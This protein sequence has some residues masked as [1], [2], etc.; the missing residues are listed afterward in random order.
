MDADIMADPTNPNLPSLDVQ[1]RVARLAMMAIATI[2]LPADFPKGARMVGF[3]LMP[4]EHSYDN[5]GIHMM[6]ALQSLADIDLEAVAVGIDERMNAPF[7]IPP[8]KPLEAT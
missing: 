6:E 7:S 5:E 3:L 4:D 1:R 8:L 2:D